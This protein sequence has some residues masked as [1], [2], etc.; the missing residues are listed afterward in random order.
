MAQRYHTAILVDADPTTFQQINNK[1]GK[2][3]FQV[4][5]SQQDDKQQTVFVTKEVEYY[6][7]ADVRKVWSLAATLK[8]ATSV[9][10]TMKLLQQS[11]RTKLGAWTIERTDAGDYLVIYVC[12]VDATATPRALKSTMEY[13]AKLTHLAKRD[14]SPETKTET[15]E[16]I[17]SS[18]LSE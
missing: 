18:W 14:L 3:A 15:P 8:E 5:F 12:K 10:T 4:D 6:E 13:V 17:L 7:Q 2:D 1:Y 9:D 16:Q 11:A